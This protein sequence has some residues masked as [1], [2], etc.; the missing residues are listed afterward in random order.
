MTMQWN[1]NEIRDKNE[2]EVMKEMNG[3]EPDRKG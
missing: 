2:N 3:N 1:E